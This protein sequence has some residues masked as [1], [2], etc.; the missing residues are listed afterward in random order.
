VHGPEVEMMNAARRGPVLAAIGSLCAIALAVSATPAAAQLLSKCAAAKKACVAKKVKALLDCHGK[1]EKKGTPVDAA[2]LAKAKAQFDGGSTP[3][4]GCFAKLEAKQNHEKLA[5]LCPSVG[6]TAAVEAEVDAFV[7]ALVCRLGG[8]ACGATPTPT[9][10]GGGTATPTPTPTSTPPLLCAVF[11][12]SGDQDCGNGC[13]PCVS[14]V[15]NGF[16]L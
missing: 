11:S 9:P 7:D 3:G 13:G 1:A 6:D 8:D 15:C 4:K 2:C 10:S 14:N 5:T 12:C 16:N